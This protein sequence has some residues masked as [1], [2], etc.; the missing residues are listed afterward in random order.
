MSGAPRSITMMSEPPPIGDMSEEQ[1]QKFADSL[2][3]MRRSRAYEA[4]RSYD[5][6]T[7]LEPIIVGA[8]IAGMFD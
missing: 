5:T 3:T 1:R 2:K 6:S 4:P 8:L 7:G